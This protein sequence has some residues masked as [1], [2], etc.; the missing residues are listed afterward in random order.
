MLTENGEVIYFIH[1]LVSPDQLQEV[2]IQRKEDLNLK[3][4]SKKLQ[5]STEEK[6]RSVIDKAVYLI[7]CEEK[8][9]LSLNFDLL[10]NFS[11]P[12]PLKFYLVTDFAEIFAVIQGLCSNLE[13]SDE[14]K[15]LSLELKDSTLKTLLKF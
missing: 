2:L 6:V 8:N 1:L 13:I 15:A 11:Q 3:P 9:D 14:I 7:Y 5:N 4:A 10:N 12:T